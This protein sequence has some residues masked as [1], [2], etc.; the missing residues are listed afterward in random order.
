MVSSN[1]SSDGPPRSAPVGREADSAPVGREADSAPVGR[2][3][4]SAP[5]GREADFDVIICG[6]GMSGLTLARQIR[7]EL[8]EWS[9]A[10]VEKVPRPLPDGCHKVGESSVELGSQYFERL[11][12]GGY[13]RERHLIKF[14]LRFYPGG[15]ELPLEARAELGPSQEPIVRSYQIDRGRFEQDVRGMNEAEGVTMIE[16]ATVREA[17]LG[18]G[19]QLHR[20]HIE[21]AGGTP[22]DLRCR[23]AVDATGRHALLRRKL[24]LTRGSGHLAHAAWFRVASRVQA[25]DLVPPSATEWHGMSFASERWR[26]TT[27]LMGAGYWVWLIPLSCG[28]TSVGI[29]T[30]GELHPFDKL[31]TPERAMKFIADYE[32][33]LAAR[34]QGEEHLDF[35]CLK[36]YSHGVARCWSTDR[37]AMVGEAGAFVDPLYSPGNDFIAFANSFTCELMRVERDG[38]DLETRV[39]ELNIQYRALVAGATSIFSHAA[40]VYGHARAMTAKVYWDNFAYWS[41]PCQY[42]LQGLYRLTGELH[43]RLTAEGARFV[44]LSDCVQALMRAWAELAPE[45][46]RPGF[47]GMPTYPSLLVETHLDLQK[48]MTP[49]ETLE[50]LRMRKAQANEIVAELVVRLVAELGPERGRMLLERVPLGRVGLQFDE[51][52]L[53][54]EGLGS[55]E[56]RHAL[57]PIA[58]DVE[59]NL[60][61]FD[62]HPQW[63][64]ALSLLR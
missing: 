64:E 40:P 54:A 60:G 59:R 36:G 18:E 41:F 45:S 31:Q 22:L 37:W 63:S 19:G 56:R 52:R 58:R 11:G 62:R 10:V 9:V 29:V 33:L 43:Q 55:V 51:A 7:R 46:P 20:L 17:E 49:E 14:G 35:H 50:Y 34:L 5:V 32:P 6:G 8:P 44:E 4:D 1:P 47:V 12:L 2:E 28:M 48:K 16:G 15:G 13:L 26:S 21:R 42:F 27:H 25:G 23:W 53:T 38:E 30:H 3:A 24:K 61:R 39:R 57:S